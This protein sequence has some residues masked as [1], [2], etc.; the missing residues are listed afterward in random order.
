MLGSPHDPGL[1]ESAINHLFDEIEAADE[2]R[3]LLRVSYMEIYNENV[4][5]LLADVSDLCRFIIQTLHSLQ[6]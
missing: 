2:K 5:D 4:T 3:F 6:C 1:I